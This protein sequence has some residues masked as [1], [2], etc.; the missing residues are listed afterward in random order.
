LIGLYVG[1]DHVRF[2]RRGAVLVFGH[3]L[4]IHKHPRATLDAAIKDA[5]KIGSKRC[6]VA[7]PSVIAFS[8]V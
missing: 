7:W 4:A 2:G 1:H 5:L 3:Q 6:I 8:T